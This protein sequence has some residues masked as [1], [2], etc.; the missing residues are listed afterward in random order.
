MKVLVFGI[1]RAAVECARERLS[2][3]GHTVKIALTAKGLLEA[4][5]KDCLVEAMVVLGE[6]DDRHEFACI[7]RNR[8][9]VKSSCKCGD[10]VDL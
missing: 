1:D 8:L 2:E 9:S 7:K 5:A 4:L 3:R 10:R 6:K